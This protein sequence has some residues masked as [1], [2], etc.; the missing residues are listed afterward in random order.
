M[1]ATEAAR[2]SHAVNV[3]GRI[4]LIL[5]GPE[6]RVRKVVNLDG[7]DRLTVL[8]REE[9]HSPLKGL[10]DAVTVRRVLPLVDAARGKPG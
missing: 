3:Q 10:R 2:C 5:R 1:P 6:L 7:R 9:A 8:E 4:W